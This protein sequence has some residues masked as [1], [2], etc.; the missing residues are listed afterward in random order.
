[1]SSFYDI[2]SVS[3]VS[4]LN[5]NK[6]GT[7]NSIDLKIWSMVKLSSERDFRY[8]WRLGSS[9]SHFPYSYRL[10]LLLSTLDT[11]LSALPQCYLA[12]TQYYAVVTW[13]CYLLL[14]VVVISTLSPFVYQSKLEDSIPLGYMNVVYVVPPPPWVTRLTCLPYCP[15]CNCAH[16]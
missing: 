12:F 16:C 13:S 5:P 10:S 4:P 15:L 8:C 3:F 6:Q 2:T 7:R 14:Q 1:M 9:F 11:I